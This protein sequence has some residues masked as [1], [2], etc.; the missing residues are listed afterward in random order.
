MPLPPLADPW[1]VRGSHS[2]CAVGL[3]GSCCS[4]APGSEPHH[5]GRAWAS[6]ARPSC[7]R[8][9]LAS[10]RHG[11]AWVQ[12]VLWCPRRC[13]REGKPWALLLQV[14]RETGDSE[15][16]LPSVAPL[17]RVSLG[18][19]SSSHLLCPGFSHKLGL[20]PVIAVCK[21]EL[22]TR[23]RRMFFSVNSY[24]GEG[25]QGLGGRWGRDQDSILTKAISGWWAGIFQMKREK[26]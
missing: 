20:R 19:P 14:L 12:R 8:G 1:G 13:E 4:S 2:S 23:E 11:E 10:G 7:R 24:T 16:L 6:W 17:G 9:S 22:N 26:F 15:A 25:G 18:R 21:P 5:W 3:G